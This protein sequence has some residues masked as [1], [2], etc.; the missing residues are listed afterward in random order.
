MLGKL[1]AYVRDN[2]CI[3]KSTNETRQDC[4]NEDCAELR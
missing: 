4:K 1:F 2:I 3:I